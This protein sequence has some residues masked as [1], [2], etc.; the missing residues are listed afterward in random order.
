MLKYMELYLSYYKDEIQQMISEYLRQFL[1]AECRITT[2][3]FPK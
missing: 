2:V 1:N 3:S